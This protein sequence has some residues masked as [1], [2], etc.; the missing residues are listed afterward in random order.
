MKKLCKKIC[1]FLFLGIM[2]M[3]LSFAQQTVDAWIQF[4]GQDRKG[5][6]NEKL[7]LSADGKVKTKLVWKQKM[8]AGFSEILALNDRIYTLYGNKIDSLHGLEYVVCYEA[9]TGKEIW[10]TPIDS[11][12]IEPDNWGR[13]F[14]F[15]TLYGRRK[16]LLF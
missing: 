14:A 9:K 5:I 4:R 1:A 13:R 10:K 11:L 15:N 8:G 16:Y 2:T 7:P 3:N 6:V 12:Y